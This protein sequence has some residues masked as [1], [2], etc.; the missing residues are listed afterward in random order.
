MIHIQ[1]LISTRDKEIF[2]IK[3]LWCPLGRP[4]CVARWNQKQG[5][6]VCPCYCGVRREDYGS[7]YVWCKYDGL[8]NSIT[9]TH[10]YSLK[11]S[12][13]GYDKESISNVGSM[14]PDNCPRCIQY[15]GDICITNGEFQN[16]CNDFTDVLTWVRSNS[17]FKNEKDV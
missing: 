5:I 15:L 11:L 1:Y 16:P 7:M 10:T 17:T 6:N 3:P 9:K 13:S 4:F 2:W 14:I 8:T 12:V